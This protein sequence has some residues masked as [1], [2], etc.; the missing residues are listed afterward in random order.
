MA[1]YDCML[2]EHARF[3]RIACPRATHDILLHALSGKQSQTTL[4][5]NE[6]LFIKVE[7]VKTSDEEHCESE[8]YY[9]EVENEGYETVF[10][11]LDEVQYDNLVY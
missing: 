2:T 11:Q 8:F 3:S 7:S 6:I 1:R 5:V 4:M 9:P 10:C